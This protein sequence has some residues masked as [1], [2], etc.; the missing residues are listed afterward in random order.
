MYNADCAGLD[1]Q[2]MEK[3]SL[4]ECNVR[5]RRL[6]YIYVDPPLMK[7]TEE[8]LLCSV[9]EDL[10]GND[11]LSYWP[12]LEEGEANTMQKWG[13]ERPLGGDYSKDAANNNPTDAALTSGDENSLTQP[14]KHRKGAPK[15]PN[16][17]R[18]SL[19]KTRHEFSLGLN[20]HR[21]GFGG[22]LSL[23]YAQKSVLCARTV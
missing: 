17:H 10:D 9:F 16:A 8:Q 2:T 15:H 23:N 21:D 6:L 18:H 20:A 14:H 3:R 19:E 22:F 4:H 13:S 7:M 12:A 11:L 1:Y 5:G